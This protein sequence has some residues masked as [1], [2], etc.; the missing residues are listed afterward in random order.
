[1]LKLYYCRCIYCGLSI[2]QCN[3]E[4][5]LTKRDINI[6]HILPKSRGGGNTWVNPACACT[7][8]NHRK[9]DRMPHEAGMK[10]LWELKT[11]Q[12]NYLLMDGS[13]PRS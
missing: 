12:T 1:M 8:C 10:L 3:G 2:G 9:A 4:K 5:I 11:P 6:D 7:P 13:V